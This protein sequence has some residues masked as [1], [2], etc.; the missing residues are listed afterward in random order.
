M[1]KDYEEIGDLKNAVERIHQLEIENNDHRFYLALSSRLLELID[2]AIFYTD[3]EL[4]FQKA[5]PAFYR[6]MGAEHGSL[7]GR[8]LHDL[9]CEDPEVF[10]SAA[11]VGLAR[12]GHWQGDIL[13]KTGKGEVKAES[14]LIAS[15]PDRSGEIEA[16]IGI[17]RDLSELQSAKAV[18]E[19]SSS[20]DA[21]TG[22][23]NREYFHVAVQDLMERCVAD[24]GTL[25]VCLLDLD[26][27][28]EINNDLS[29]EAGD[30]ILRAVGRRLSEALRTGD[31]LARSGGDEFA[32]AF[33]LK[34]E[35]E[36]RPLAARILGLFDAPFETAG[37]LIY[38]NA[39][40]GV[41]LCPDH[42]TEAKKLS[43]CADLALQSK[44]ANAKSSYAV[45]H[46][47]LG[48]EAP[49]QGLPLLRA[50]DGHRGPR[51][52][53]GRPGRPVSTSS[54]SPSST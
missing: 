15:V 49:R 47:D 18:L 45:Y 38:M 33:P 20:H 2:E 52:S 21:L 14:L 19:Y 51:Q 22:L 35:A 30:D 29:R 4:R 53:F 24:G 3:K 37:R 31:L 8:E 43:A 11:V 50:Q 27:F 48:H 23:P 42:G 46:E 17:I 25:A 16:Y 1:G 41:S 40:M 39:T 12:E 44:K 34:S 13:R 5:N 36:L 54:I 6:L 7:E 9:L 10:A 32:L 26:D 28:K